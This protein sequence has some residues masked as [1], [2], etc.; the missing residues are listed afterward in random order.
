[1]A[2]SKREIFLQNDKTTHIFTKEPLCVISNIENVDLCSTILE[3]IRYI[4]SSPHTCKFYTLI[5]GHIDLCTISY[6]RY[7]D[8]YLDSC[9]RKLSYPL[10]PSMTLSIQFNQSP[11][12]NRML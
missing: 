10:M 4:P 9:M 5:L 11:S 2:Y 6:Y 3:C 8:F 7:I 1:M 12:P